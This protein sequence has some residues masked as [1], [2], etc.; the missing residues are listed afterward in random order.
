MNPTIN[1]YLRLERILNKEKKTARYD[2]TA[3]A[4]YYPPLETLKNN[5]GQLF[6]YLNRSRNDKSTTPEHYLQASKDSMNLT[7]LF[8]YW[9][10]GKMSGFCSGYPSTK[11]IFD[12]KKK[13]PNPFYEN[14]NDAFLFIIYWDKEAQEPIPTPTAIEMIVLQN[15]KVLIDAYRKQLMLGGFDEE[16]N[17]LRGQAKPIFKY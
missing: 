10:D 9:E 1:C 15:T 14:R 7:G 17:M 16:L 8:H 11:E 2:C 13:T 4:G 5:K 6:F 12:N 3:F